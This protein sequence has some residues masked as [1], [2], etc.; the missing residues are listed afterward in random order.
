MF[1]RISC[2]ISAG[3]GLI[4]AKIYANRLFFCA[5]IGHFKARNLEHWLAAKRAA[6]VFKRYS[7]RDNEGGL[8]MGGRFFLGCHSAL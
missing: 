7:I 3:V 2:E 1:C 8:F 4:E 5:L 6:S